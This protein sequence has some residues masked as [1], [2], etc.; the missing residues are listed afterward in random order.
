MEVA[1][2]DAAE[3]RPWAERWREAGVCSSS[4]Y[5]IHAQSWVWATQSELFSQTNRALL[6]LCASPST[7]SFQFLLCVCVFHIFSWRWKARCYSLSLLSAWNSASFEVSSVSSAFV[8]VQPRPKSST[9]WR[10]LFLPLFCGFS[11]WSAATCRTHSVSPVSKSTQMFFL[12]R[13]FHYMQKLTRFHKS[14]FSESFWV[15]VFT[16]DSCKFINTLQPPL[17]KALIQT[18]CNVLSS[19]PCPP[20]HPALPT[21]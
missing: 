10:E 8:S 4:W 19:S 11:H 2:S 9:R 12:H 20:P 3:C 15:L 7:E 18:L 14:G 16:R 13:V 1:D 6:D 17:Q 5:G 21:S